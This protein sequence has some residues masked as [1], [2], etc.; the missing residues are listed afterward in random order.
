MAAVQRIMFIKE[1][2]ENMAR[3][4]RSRFIPMRSPIRTSSTAFSTAW[5]ALRTP[6]LPA[7][8]SGWQGC[9]SGGSEERP[10]RCRRGLP[11]YHAVAGR[12]LLGLELVGFGFRL[13]SGDRAGNS[14]CHRHF[15][16]LS[17][18]D[19]EFLVERTDRDLAVDPPLNH[20]VGNNIGGPD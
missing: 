10:R 6:S 14:D 11:P 13:G 4:D 16:G 5:R 3:K 18:L 9:C 2:R 7:W 1:A 20:V 15:S 12:E 19:L 8:K 17:R